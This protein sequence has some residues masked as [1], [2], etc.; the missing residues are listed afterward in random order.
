[1]LAYGQPQILES[2]KNT[3]P[4]RL[5][6][7]LFPI[8]DLRLAVETA[9]R[10]LTKE[11]IDRQLAGQSSST[12][13]MNI[14]DGYNSKR[15]ATFDMQ[16]SLGDEIDKL[17]SMM[18]K[19]TA[20]GNNQNKPFKTRIYQGKRRGQKR[21]YYDQ[22]NYQNRYRSNSED[23]RISFRGS[24]QCRQNYR[25]RSQYV[26]NNDCRKGNFREM[27]NYRGKNFRGGYRDD[28]RNDDFGRFCLTRDQVRHI[29]KTL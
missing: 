15:I 6:W 20:Q 21:N 16:D 25:G 14:T 23:R 19:L 8:E 1:M 7:V 9:R 17:T 22:S 10:I 4:T 27:Q 13:F 3:L 5:Y 18:S 12:P 26:N 29:Y 24:A 28:Y 11:K 2:F